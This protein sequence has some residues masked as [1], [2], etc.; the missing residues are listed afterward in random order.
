MTPEIMVKSQC[1]LNFRYELQQQQFPH[2]QNINAYSLVF[3]WLILFYNNVVMT[4]VNTI[5]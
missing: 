2:T 3:Y 5:T 1:A 4:C